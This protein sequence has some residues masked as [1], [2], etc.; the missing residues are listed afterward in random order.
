MFV[1]DLRQFVDFLLVPTV[2][3][4]SPGTDSS[5]VSSNNKTD[6]HDVSELLLK[7]ALNTKTLTLSDTGNDSS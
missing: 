7:V 4:F 6:R 2:R 3:W 1:I 5:V